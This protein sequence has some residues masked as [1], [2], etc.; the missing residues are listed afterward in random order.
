[1]RF[2]TVLAALALTVP[3]MI[4]TTVA[5]AH[6]YMAGLIVIGHPWARATPASAPVAGGYVTLTNTG[7][8][9][10]VFLSGSS[11]LSEKFELHESTV[12]DGVAK[13]RQIADGIEI[14]PGE[15]VAL[16]AGGTHIMF[17][18]PKKQLVEGERFPVTLRFKNAGAITVDF[19]VQGL[20]ASKA[21][22]THD[23]HKA[24]E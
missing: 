23:D 8:E 7:K 14:K 1:M 21:A 22:D 11:P 3:A 20:G 16:K 18:K 19:A 5:T 2:K 6:E 9:T 4:M 12:V 10:D 15:T 17:V 13:M 24:K